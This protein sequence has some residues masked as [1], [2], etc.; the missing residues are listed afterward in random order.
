MTKEFFI[1]KSKQLFYK[2]FF[3]QQ[4]T[5]EFFLVFSFIVRPRSFPWCFHNQFFALAAYLWLAKSCANIGYNC[6]GS[7]DI[8]RAFSSRDVDM[9]CENWHTH[10]NCTLGAHCSRSKA[11]GRNFTFLQTSSIYEKVYLSHRLRTLNE[12]FFHQ[13]PK[14]LGF[15]LGQTILTDKIWGIWGIFSWFISTDFCTASPL[16][17]F[18]INQSLFLQK[19]KPL[20]LNLKYLSG[21][22]IWIWEAEN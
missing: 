15:G 10:L 9:I 4:C 3:T 6:K 12:A 1:K 22:G 14:L 2:T 17:M 5:V 11:A 20:N 16:S 13:N 21:I 19:T 8:F 18:S 7:I